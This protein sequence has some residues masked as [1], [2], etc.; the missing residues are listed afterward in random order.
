MDPL[1]VLI[2]TGDDGGIVLAENV[3]NDYLKS[4]PTPRLRAGALHILQD[5]L[6]PLGRRHRAAKRYLL[7]R[8]SDTP[9]TV[10]ARSR[11]HNDARTP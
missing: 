4:F 3:V 1:R 9:T 8:C 2:A 7:I 5:A 10:C 11:S 6:T